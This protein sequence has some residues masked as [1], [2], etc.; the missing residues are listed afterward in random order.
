VKVKY[1]NHPRQL[2]LSRACVND[3]LPLLLSDNH[4]THNGA[5]DELR[6]DDLRLGLKVNLA[7]LP[8]TGD[9]DTAT[10]WPWGTLLQF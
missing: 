3:G 8:S 10:W 9:P 5:V 6:D 1:I 7:L 4:K 2:G